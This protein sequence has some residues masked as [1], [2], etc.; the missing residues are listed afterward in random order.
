MILFTR[1]QVDGTKQ[2]PLEQMDFLYVAE[3]HIQ[4]NGIKSCLV[5]Y[6]QTRRCEGLGQFSAIMRWLLRKVWAVSFSG[7]SQ[8]G[9]NHHHTYIAT[10]LILF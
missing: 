8:V 6:C 2:K 7:D 1:I 5:I 3:D 9:I 4:K 10:Y